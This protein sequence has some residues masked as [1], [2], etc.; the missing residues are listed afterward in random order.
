M[1]PAILDAMEDP[2]WHL[3]EP[4]DVIVIFRTPKTSVAS[5]GKNRDALGDS[6]WQRLGDEAFALNLNERG[7][8]AD[9]FTS[10]LRAKL[11]ADDKC[12]LLMANSQGAAIRK[13][14]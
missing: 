13:I 10:E 12:W 4:G 1:F 8:D 5:G 3:L 2:S 11:N 7:I 9:Q 6:S 14:Q